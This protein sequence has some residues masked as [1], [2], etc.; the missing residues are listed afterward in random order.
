MWV[1]GNTNAPLDRAQMRH[2]QS[3]LLKSLMEGAIGL[4]RCDEWPIGSYLT[5]SGLTYPPGMYASKE[6]LIELVKVLKLRPGTFYA[7][8]H[9]SYGHKALDGYMEMLHIALLTKVPIRVPYRC[10][11]SLRLSVLPHLH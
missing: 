11:V 7:P 2:M 4:S 5:H 3:L 1:G 6:E 8:H 10:L 9:R